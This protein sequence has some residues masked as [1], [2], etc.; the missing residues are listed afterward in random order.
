MEKRLIE[1]TEE[2]FERVDKSYVCHNAVVRTTDCMSS[3]VDEIL[4]YNEGRKSM[5]KKNIC[6]QAPL[7]VNAYFLSNKNEQSS[8]PCPMIS[9]QYDIIYM[10]IPKKEFESML[11][12]REK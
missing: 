7:F 11:M 10:V 8:P 5:L 1:I 6:D 4:Y 3:N 9:I 12:A 2:E